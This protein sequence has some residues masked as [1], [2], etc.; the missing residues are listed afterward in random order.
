MILRRRLFSDETVSC[1]VNT[2][3]GREHFF[4]C[5]GRKAGA[6]SSAAVRL[7]WKPPASRPRSSGTL[8]QMNWRAIDA[9][10]PAFKQGLRY[11]QY[12][13]HQMATKSVRL[14]VEANAGLV[15]YTRPEVV[16]L[17]TG[18]V[19]YVPDLPGLD[20]SKIHTAIQV[21]NI[22]LPGSGKVIIIGGGLVGCETALHLTQ[23]GNRVT[24]VE[25]LDQV[26]RDM[27]S[28]SRFALLEELRK[29]GVELKTG[30]R[31]ERLGPGKIM[32]RGCQGEIDEMEADYIVIALGSISERRLIQDLSDHFPQVMEAGD[33][34]SPRKVGDAVHEGFA[35]GWRIC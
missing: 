23:Q 11:L 34:I 12:L 5:K 2:T 15:R 14:N 28:V 35:A 20:S 1:V 9:T 25:A 19:P 24:L 3:C 7:A 33:C 27:N 17:A 26:A 18:A 30:L 31:F 8:K 29:A 4:T 32:C 13:R 22:G 10:R 6:L 16:V 21:L